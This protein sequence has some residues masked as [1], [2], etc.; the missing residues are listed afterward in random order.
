MTLKWHFCNFLC[1]TI[2]MTKSSELFKEYQ[3]KLKSFIKFKFVFIFNISVIFFFFQNYTSPKI[4][5]G[6]E[7][8]YE[9][10]KSMLQD[11]LCCEWDHCYDRF[12]SINEFF[13]HV[14]S[15]VQFVGKSETEFS[16]KWFGCTRNGKGFDAR[17][18]S[19]FDLR[20]FL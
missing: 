20:H 14:N 3:D 19:L 9:T 13:E 18:M 11:L 15:H 16:C 6:R 12:D 5:S 4:N 10:S 7:S 17:L 1:F 2:D 8:V